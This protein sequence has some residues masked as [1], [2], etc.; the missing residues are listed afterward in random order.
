MPTSE[1]KW[2]EATQT[3]ACVVILDS[4]LRPQAVYLCLNLGSI[5]DHL[6]A[7]GIS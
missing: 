5:R 2:A 3:W 7:L 6:L 1:D 4:E